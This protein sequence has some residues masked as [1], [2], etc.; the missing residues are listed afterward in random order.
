MA[1][2][3]PLKTT[4]DDD[5][6][7]KVN[8]Q[9]TFIIGS[10]YPAAGD[11]PYLEMAEAGF[12][13]VHT[14][15]A[16]AD[17]DKALEAKLMTWVTVGTLDLAKL[18]ESAAKLTEA[19]NKVKDHPAVAFLETV[20]EPAWTWQKA[21]ARVP[22]E[23]LVKAY[24]VIK[25]AD[26]NH[27]LYTNHAPTNLVKTIQAYNGGTDIVA[28]DIYPVN[29]GGLRTMFAIFPDGQQGDFNN[30]TISQ[31]GRYADKMRLVAGPERPVFMVLQ[32]FA[33]EGL[34]SDKPGVEE[35][36]EEKV[37]YPTWFQ[38]RFMAFQSIIRGANGVVY[39]G[40]HTMPQ[41]S[42]YWDD[43]KRV[44]R[45]L[46]DLADPLAARSTDITL[47]CD[48]QEMGH[49]VDEGVQWRAK[50]HEGKLYLLTCNADKNTCKA[51]LSGLTG[52]KSCSVLNE[53]RELPI[54]ND[55]IT[56][57]WRRFEVHVYV[58]SR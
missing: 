12:N 7:I 57:T 24:P 23:A 53:A 2:N 36:R 32:G 11:R 50:E 35:R 10:Y 26:P 19:V 16:K 47:E 52:F 17:L 55:S 21:E 6:M 56:D 38:H 46:A 39:W 3:A 13:L 48:Y 28:A 29:P 30:E 1:Q 25:A 31:V 15:D 41:P 43:L 27:L 42:S 51:A 18:D 9:R 5:G 14:S 34:V 45:E 58:L 33:W 37:L 44:T 40:S 54:E 20:D 8:G 22:A 49:S 4:Y